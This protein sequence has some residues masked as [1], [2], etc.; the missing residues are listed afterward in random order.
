M[1]S[2]QHWVSG[3]VLN[4][5]WWSHDGVGYPTCPSRPSLLGA[6]RRQ[7]GP[8]AIGRYGLDLVPVAEQAKILSTGY[9]QA[10]QSGRGT[11]FLQVSLDGCTTY[12]RPIGAWVTVTVP[13]APGTGYLEASRRGNRGLPVKRV[14]TGNLGILGLIGKQEMGTHLS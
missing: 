5:S 4:S 7:I 3:L 12:N 1:L 10:K 13:G 9:L 11:G 14:V 8:L 2:E 6:Q